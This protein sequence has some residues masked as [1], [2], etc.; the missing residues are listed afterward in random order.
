MKTNKVNRTAPHPTQGNCVK[1]KKD[2]T[3]LFYWHNGKREKCD[4]CC[5]KYPRQYNT[6]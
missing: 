5:L 3:Y 4:E 2:F 6:R 1:C